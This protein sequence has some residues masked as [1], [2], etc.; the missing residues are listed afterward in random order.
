MYVCKVF[1]ERIHWKDTQTRQFIWLVI[2]N[3]AFSETTEI[4]GNTFTF[5]KILLYKLRFP[6]S[7]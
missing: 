2:D 6:I 5:G 4:I 3:D 7:L 1:N